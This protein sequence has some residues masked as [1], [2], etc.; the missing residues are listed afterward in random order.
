MGVVSQLNMDIHPHMHRR[1]HTPYFTQSHWCPSVSAMVTH[2]LSD[3]TT[4][5]TEEKSGRVLTDSALIK[6]NLKQSKLDKVEE[7]ESNPRQQSKTKQSKTTSQTPNYQQKYQN[8]NLE[9]CRKPPLP[10]LSS[11]LASTAPPVACGPRILVM[12]DTKSREFHLWG[13]ISTL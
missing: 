6:V 13:A 2:V 10:H 1:T 4:Q 12:N 3:C 5:L 8:R 7:G 11:F 9:K